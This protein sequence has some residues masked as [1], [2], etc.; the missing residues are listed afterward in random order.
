MKKYDS[1]YK[2]I[3]IMDGIITDNGFVGVGSKWEEKRVGMLIKTKDLVS[4]EKE[5]NI[6]DGNF[7]LRK[8]IKGRFV[9]LNKSETIEPVNLKE[10]KY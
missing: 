4:S 10:W 1:P 7:V 6:T 2:D 3:S 5:F 9:D 8:S